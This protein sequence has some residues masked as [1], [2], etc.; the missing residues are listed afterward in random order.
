VSAPAVRRGRLVAALVV[1]VVMLVGSIGAAVAWGGGLGQKTA[2]AGIGLRLSGSSTSSCPTPDLAKPVVNVSLTDM[3]GPMMGSRGGMMGWRDGRIGGAHWLL[4]DRATVPAGNVTFLVANHGSI[5]HELVVL[6][7]PGNLSV[8][9]RPVGADGKIDEAGS[10][11][12]ASNSCGQGA[13]DGIRPGAT[14]WVTSTL[15]P[16]RYEL[17][18]NLAG[19]YEAGMFTEI[20][21]S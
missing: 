13:G 10:V 9:N 17:V 5:V 4:A 1:A 20:T 11:G 18:C 14:S 7:L 21:V 3:G 12:E 2:G 6:P 16:G 19:H 15:A 8:G